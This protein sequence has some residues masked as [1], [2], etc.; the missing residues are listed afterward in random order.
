MI[1]PDANGVSRSVRPRS[2]VITVALVAVVGTLVNAVYRPPAREE[3]S[4]M[5]V[6]GTGPPDT[7]AGMKA[8][9]DAVVFATY[10]GERRTLRDPSL[11]RMVY[12]FEVREVLKSHPALRSGSRRLDLELLGGTIEEPNL[13]RHVV[14][15]GRRELIREHRYVLFINHRRMRWIPASGQDGGGA[16]IYDVSGDRVMNLTTE[17]WNNTDPPA[18]LMFLAELRAP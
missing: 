5:A 15:S 17:Q 7:A 2:I 14:V 11:P 8:A 6:D 16:S 13:V 12:R 9:A 10:W 1:D 3:E 18:T 4:L